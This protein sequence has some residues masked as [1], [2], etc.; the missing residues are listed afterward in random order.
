MVLILVVSFLHPHFLFFFHTIS[1]PPLSACFPHLGC[2]L[3]FKPHH[4]VRPN[5]AEVR[6]HLAPC[7]PCVPWSRMILCSMSLTP[8]RFFSFPFPKP[9][10]CIFYFF[11]NCFDPF[12]AKGAVAKGCICE[13]TPIT[14]GC[15]GD[16]TP[17]TQPPDQLFQTIIHNK[18]TILDTM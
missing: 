5:P 9:V 4:C 6:G 14:Q 12:Y 16:G 1:A 17:M 8:S 18:E 2:P 15:N 13:R 10:V 11:M 7:T 3:P